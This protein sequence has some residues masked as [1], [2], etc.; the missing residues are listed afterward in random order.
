MTRTTFPFDLSPM[1]QWEIAATGVPDAMGDG[2][3]VLDLEVLHDGD[4]PCA[5]SLPVERAWEDLLLEAEARL[6]EQAIADSEA[7]RDAMNDW[8]HDI[9][10]EG[11]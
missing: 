8:R 7:S 3:I 2:F 5:W 11:Y 6:T 1:R 9:R 4:Q 10:R